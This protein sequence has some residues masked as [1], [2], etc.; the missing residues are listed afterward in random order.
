MCVTQIVWFDGNQMPS[1]IQIFNY[2][3]SVPEKDRKIKEYIR[4]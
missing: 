4:E 2:M 1:I 3:Q